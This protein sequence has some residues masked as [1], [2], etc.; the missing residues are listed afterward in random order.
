MNPFLEQTVVTLQRT[1]ISKS[2]IKKLLIFTSGVLTA[3]R[4]WVLMFNTIL[5]FIY[6]KLSLIFLLLITEG[7]PSRLKYLVCLKIL[8]KKTNTSV[9][10]LSVYVSAS[11]YETEFL[12]CCGN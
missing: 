5:L 12:K 7:D 11:P 9:L 4:A 6:R 10:R 3:E 1:T 8:T 2:S